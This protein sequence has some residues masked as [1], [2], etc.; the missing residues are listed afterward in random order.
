MFLQAPYYVTVIP[1]GEPNGAVLKTLVDGGSEMQ[2]TWQVDLPAGTSITVQVKDA[3]GTPNYTDKVTIGAGSDTSCVNNNV[4]VC[5]P[6]SLFFS[7][8]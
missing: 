8:L 3:S 4:V 2:Y 6:S 5:V 7:L 1:G